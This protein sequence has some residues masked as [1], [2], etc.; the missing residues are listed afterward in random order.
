[1]NYLTHRTENKNCKKVKKADKAEKKTSSSY[2]FRA[3]IY[4]V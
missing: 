3:V 1:M 2:F 4:L